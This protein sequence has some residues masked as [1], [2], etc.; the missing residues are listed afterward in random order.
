MPGQK[1]KSRAM[2]LLQR[3]KRY[4]RRRKLTPEDLA[5]ARLREECRN[6]NGQEFVPDTESLDTS[7]SNDRTSD[8]HLPTDFE[9]GTVNVTDSDSVTR[10]ST[11]S[12]SDDDE[13]ARKRHCPGPEGP[14]P[15][16]KRTYEQAQLGP[17]T[18]KRHQGKLTV[19]RP[20]HLG[21]F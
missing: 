21:H 6:P 2:S 9:I 16:E 15:G 10:I 11:T 5:L 8:T 7:T 17:S 4:W 18:S 13:P 14:Q 3:E 12:D 1:K 19:T 20:C